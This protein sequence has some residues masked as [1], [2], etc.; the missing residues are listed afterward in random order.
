MAGQGFYS[1]KGDFI[2]LSET[3]RTR[4]G[5]IT[6]TANLPE[7]LALWAMRKK[8]RMTLLKCLFAARYI[9]NIVDIDTLPAFLSRALNIHIKTAKLKT[10][11]LLKRNWIGKRGHIRK[12]R[13][14]AIYVGAQDPTEC[15]KI[16]PIVNDMWLADLRKEIEAAFVR[17]HLILEKRRELR[18]RLSSKD[19]QAN[20]KGRAGVPKHRNV[21]G[22]QSGYSK[23][24]EPAQTPANNLYPDHSGGMSI[25]L[26][27]AVWGV[28][29]TTAQRHS[30]ELH[31]QGFAKFENRSRRVSITHDH[32]DFLRNNAPELT[33]GMVKTLKGVIQR[34]SQKVVFVRGKAGNVHRFAA[35]FHPLKPVFLYSNAE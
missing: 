21:V 2:P 9:G 6:H 26:R 18:K 32:L 17:K 3:R 12:I 14:I 7:D 16:E 15:L 28:S 4:K 22:T 8:S 27:A 30:R 11:E 20:A 25:S 1:V 24:Q 13:S 5:A 19:A 29:K 34:L 31:E 23:Q 35:C 33:T 10:A